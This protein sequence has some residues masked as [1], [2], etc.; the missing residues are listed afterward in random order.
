MFNKALFKLEWKSNYKI[1]IIFCLV[2]TMYITIMISMFDPELGS[3]LDEFAKSMPEIMA[4]VGM[5]GVTTTLI[6]F[7]SS[8][9]YGFIMIA[10]PLIFSVLLTL[11][12]VVKKVDTGVMGYLLSS[13]IERKA[14]W[15]TQLLVVITNLAV[16]I[17]FATTLG[18]VCSQLMFAGALD[19]KSFI[20]LNIG[21]LILH[22]AMAGFCFMCSC[23]FNEYRIAS[24]FG[25]GVPII[26]IMIQMLSNMH[27]S[28]NV[29]KY[30]TLLTLFD[31][32]RIIVGDGEGYLML[33]V[34]IVVAGICFSIGG[35][36]FNKKSMSL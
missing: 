36:V 23:I 25:A 12:L 13:G 29:L 15:F 24:L 6:E 1:L 33:G 11:R 21:V 19:I 4:M 3:I 5:S 17:I 27:G 9:L 31:P 16:L 28:M 7:I 34:L 26:F 32:T 10:V 8:Y 22:L 2:L 30:V 18:I 35:I 14:V 20:N